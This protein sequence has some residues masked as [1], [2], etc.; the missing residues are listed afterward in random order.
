MEDVRKCKFCGQWFSV[1]YK[2]IKREYCSHKCA[3]QASSEV[4]KRR[5]KFI[6]KTCGKE[7][8]VIN[9]S[10]PVRLRSG[11]IQYCST[12]CMGIGMRK[13]KAVKCLNCGNEFET[14]RHRFCSQKC[15]C[16]YR[17]KSN[18]GNGYWYENGYKVLWNGGNSIK[19]HIKVM[20]DF[21]GRELTKDEVV[22]HINGVKDDNRIDNLKLMTKGEHSSYHRYQEI[23]N[24]VK[25]FGRTG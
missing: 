1:Q 6:C 22:H 5:T 9:S 20:Q 12:R 15:A 7:F 17:K 14:T 18:P 19:E 24:G 3:N 25:I 4:R 23:N 10:I 16:E 2:S 8:E 21:L 11:K 13:R